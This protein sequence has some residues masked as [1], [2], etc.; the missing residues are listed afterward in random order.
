M[1]VVAAIGEVHQVAAMHGIL[2]C[3]GGSCSLLNTEAISI[4]NKA[5]RFT[6]LG[7][8]LQLTSLSPGIAPSTIGQRVTNLIV[9]DADAIERSQ[10]VLPD[11][12]TVGK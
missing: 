4:V 8:A 1:Q 9:G 2:G 5:D 10:L 3:A 6:T 12:S 11:R 7:H